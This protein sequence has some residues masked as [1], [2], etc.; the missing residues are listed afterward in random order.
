MRRATS[1]AALLDPAVLASIDS[2][3]LLARGVVEG[4]LAGLHRAP[5]LGTSLDFAEH[6]AYEPGDDI[7]RVDWRLYGRTDRHYVRLYEA[8]TNADF[9][10]LVD[11]SR[12]LDFRG[13]P[14]RLTKFDY[15]RFLAASLAYL[16][17]TQ[18]DR[19]GLT[20]FAGEVIESIPPAARHRDFVLRALES[21]EPAEGGGLADAAETLG[22][23][24][25]R[26]GL[27]GVVSDFYEPP[28]VTERAFAALRGRG[29]DVIA[30]H[31]LDPWE[32]SLPRMEATL[33]EDLE[34]GR[35]MPVDPVEAGERFR[36]RV[37]EH[38]R[39]V[40]AALLA[41]RVDH[42]LL[43]T[44]TPLSVALARFLAHRRVALRT[45]RASG[46][47]AFGGARRAA[48]ARGG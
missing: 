14:D 35:R 20:T 43:D 47:A 16:A 25:K 29:H 39:A 44:A 13:A 10:L 31:V 27:V 9:T 48:H 1:G 17:S 32:R 38:L 28:D 5:H 3:E 12:S 36:A 23:S 34:T 6:R 7:R 41:L 37:D 18:R 22:G 30:F 42:V 11:V 26:R 33:F 46:R 40:A 2:L 15:A 24:L 19:V 4:F 45:R 8:E 21:A